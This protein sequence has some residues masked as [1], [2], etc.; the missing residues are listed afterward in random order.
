MYYFSALCTFKMDWATL[1]Q[2]FP[3]LHAAQLHFILRC[4]DIS[5]TEEAPVEWMPI[6]EDA[7]D[8]LNAS[9][10]ACIGM[11]AWYVWWHVVM[12]TV[13]VHVQGYMY[14]HLPGVGSVK[15]SVLILQ[16]L[17]MRALTLVQNFTFHC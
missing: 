14:I 13:Y 7:E 4:Y 11:A 16:L 5:L 17:L 12:A 9:K 6:P 1:R 2:E 8:A 15:C 10:F 3:V